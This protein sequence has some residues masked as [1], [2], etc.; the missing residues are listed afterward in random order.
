LKE[1]TTSRSNFFI[2]RNL[3]YARSSGFEVELRKRRFEHW[4]GAIAYTYSVA[5]GKSSDPN[6]LKL[7]QETGGD[8][9]ET[10]LAE[11]YMWW[12]RPH[13]FTAWYSLGFGPGERPRL[14]G[15]RLPDDWYLSLYTLFQSGRAYTPENVFGEP[16][17]QDYSKNGP[18]E[19]TTN[20]KF[21]KGLNFFGTKWEASL[22]IFNLFNHRTALT[23]DRV[24]GKQFEPGKGSL[25]SPYENTANL[26]L[27]D[28]ELIEL[29]G[30]SVGADQSEEEVA[31]GIRRTIIANQYRYSNPAYRSPPRSIR[32]GLGVE[33]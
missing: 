31:A 30:V 22:E 24:T 33:W 17:G 28:A 12:N 5:K 6:N 7:V 29:T 14:F 10:E 26:D 18:Y 4:S 16:V 25:D 2:Y 13:K 32:I 1:R 11:M 23:F 8:A 9:R 27:S 20:L 3:D 19:T 21:R 15:R